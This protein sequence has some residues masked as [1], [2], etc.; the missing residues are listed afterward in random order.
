M[1]YLHSKLACITMPVLVMTASALVTF[2][3]VAQDDILEELEEVIVTGTYIRRT[4]QA[5]T[6]TPLPSF[7]QSDICNSCAKDIRD[8]IE[9]LPINAGA[10]NN[11]DNL[12]Q[13]FTAGTSNINLRGLGVSSTLV[14]LNGKR[15]VTSAVQTDPGSSF[16]DTASLVPALAVERLEILK[17]GASAIYGS[18]A[19][20]GVANFITRDNFEGIEVQWEH[21]S[22]TDNGSQDD[23]NIDAVIGGSM[24]DTG[25]FLFAASFLDRSSLV[26]GEVDWLV[27]QNGSS[28]FGNPGSYVVP[29]QGQTVADRDCEVN[30]GILQTLSSGSTVCRFDFGPQV[31][32]VPDEQRLQGF[33]RVTLDW[34]DTTKIW[35]EIGYARNKITREVSPSFPVLNTP[36][37]PASHPENYF[38]EDVFF[39]GRPYGNGSP[40][41]INNYDH[42][43]FR[44]AFGAS[45]EFTES[46]FW[47]LS[48]VTSQNDALINVRDVIAN[49]FQAALNGLGGIN[50]VGTTPGVDGCLYFNPFSTS[51]T[52][53]PNDAELKA[54]IIGDYIGDA[55]S[56]MKIA[57]VIFSGNDLFDMGGGA[58]GFAIGA[59][60]R[61]ESLSYVYDSITQQ[62]GFAFL[63]GNPNFTGDR[64]VYAI[65]G[66]LRLPLSERLELSAAVRYEDYGGKVGDTTD[67]KL[68]I[69]WRPTDE[70]SVRGSVGTS[71]RAPSIFQTKGIQTGFA[72]ITDADGST[73]FAGNRTVGSDNLV[74]ETSTAYNTGI[75]WSP[76]D[77]L[78]IDLDYW[79]FE[80]EDVLTKNSAQA[81]VNAN[82]NDERVIRTSAGTIAI[83]NTSFINANAITTDGIDL[84]VRAYFETAL[85]ALSPSFDATY[86]MTYDLENSQG[87]SIDGAGQRNGTNFGDPSPELR[88]NLGL[89]WSTE[90]HSASAYLRHVSG[91]DDEQK[92]LDIDN[93]T[94]LDLQYSYN[95]GDIL[96]AESEMSLTIGVINATNENPPFVAIAGNYDPR[97]GDPRGRRAYVKIGTTF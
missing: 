52:T 38:G 24:G 19:V 73:T 6:S 88:A 51:F 17:D 27:P 81:I 36:V 65:F 74:P 71:F 72:N 70:I 10:Q 12:T 7:D 34:S 22:R 35:S 95:F 69:M 93:Y 50:C 59:Q 28:G 39:Q 83:V 43:T 75:S 64:D 25:H 9:I 29:S 61:E 68:S 60:Y 84:A 47:D 1:K 8:L 80:F 58:A 85:G 48:Y 13:N 4:S 62:D 90:Q 66:E 53:A 37:V 91:Y 87:I 79:R 20:A 15:Q 82:P 40:T 44:F 5:H 54:F 46:L 33:A 3:T 94:T 11:S 63:I 26:A 57:E 86:V 31:T 30:G 32:F 49:N 97:T 78:E 92:N 77:V 89:N 55:E 67:P 14:L 41:E 76:N 21:R 2:N 96:K 16:V 56:E 18:D 42:N 45:G 23:T